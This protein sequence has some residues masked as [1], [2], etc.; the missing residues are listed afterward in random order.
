MRKIQVSKVS[1]LLP[2]LHRL[3]GDLGQWSPQLS[4]F[5]T[6]WGPCWLRQHND[7]NIF[8]MKPLMVYR[9]LGVYCPIWFSQSYEVGIYFRGA[10]VGSQKCSQDVRAQTESCFLSPAHVT[11]ASGEMTGVTS[12][13]S[14]RPHSGVQRNRGDWNGSVSLV[15]SHDKT[16]IET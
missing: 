12:W 9:P 14:P 3:L 1:C 2:E 13:G 6:L 5:I 11:L 10:E 16:R 7:H 15:L 8:M 4:T